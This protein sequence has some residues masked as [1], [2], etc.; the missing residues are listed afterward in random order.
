MF[1][2]KNSKKMEEKVK[3]LFVCLG[4]ICRSPAAEGVFREKAK[5]AGLE[6]NFEIDS[7]GTAGYH[8]GESAD[9]RMITHCNERG[10]DITPHRAR[11]LSANDLKEYDIILA[12]DRSNYYNITSLDSDGTYREKIRMMTDFVT[13]WNVNEVP[14]PYY[15]G[16]E[17]FHH[18]IDLL[19]DG[20]DNLL[21][22]LLNHY[23]PK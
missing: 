4:N 7:A 13:R 1:V 5:I 19:E 21:N 6:S 10:Y 2:L 9:R 18:V 15:D 17:A 16:P 14:D 20:C 3:V 11:K 23:N 22:Y 12:M 8:I